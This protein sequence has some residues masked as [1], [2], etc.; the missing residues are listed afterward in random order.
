MGT[1]A[2]LAGKW[3]QLLKEITPGMRRAAFLNLDWFVPCTVGIEIELKLM[4]A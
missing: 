3:I 4:R 2:P 1:E